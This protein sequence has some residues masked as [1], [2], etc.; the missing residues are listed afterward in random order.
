MLEAAHRAVPADGLSLTWE[1]RDIRA[2]DS[3]LGQFDLALALDVLNELASLRDL[4]QVFLAVARVLE[5]TKLLVFDLHT[6][7]GLSERGADIHQMIYDSEQLMVIARSEYDHDRQVLQ[8]DYTIFQRAGDLWRRSES[9]RTLRG[10]P[11]QATATLL[12]RCGYDV[13]T[14]MTTDFALYEPGMTPAARV[15]FVARRSAG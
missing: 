10:F 8:M 6:I 9:R 4:E 3:M 15:F 5:S 7:Q 14:I 1:Q 12:Q 2:L 13:M 11:I